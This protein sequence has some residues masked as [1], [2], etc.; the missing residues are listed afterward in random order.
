LKSLGHHVMSGFGGPKSMTCCPVPPA[1][2]QARRRIAIE[3]FSSTAQIG[4]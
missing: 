3:E 1:G 2:P 4:W